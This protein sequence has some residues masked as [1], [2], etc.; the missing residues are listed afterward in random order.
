MRQITARYATW[1]RVARSN[2]IVSRKR[3]T[4]CGNPLDRSLKI[5]QDRAE[6]VSAEVITKMASE[7]TLGKRKHRE[8]G[9][10]ET[11]G[12]PSQYF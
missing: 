6:R 12:T 2:S 9:A 5:H 7:S 8:E 1:R 3:P 11:G 10:E 4:S